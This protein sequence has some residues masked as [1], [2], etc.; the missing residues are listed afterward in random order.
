M[1]RIPTIKALAV[2]IKELNLDEYIAIKPLEKKEYY[3]LSSSQKRLYILKDLDEQGITYNIPFIV[4]LAGSLDNTRF[5][6][7]FHHLIQRHESLRT[8]FVLVNT[9]PAQRIHDKVEFEMEYYTSAEK[10]SADGIVKEFIRSF[11]LSRAP[12]LRVG[13]IKETGT[14]HIL[15][16]DMHHIIAD[17]VSAGV[18]AREFMLL[19]QGTDLPE[20]KIQYKD[21]SCWQNSRKGKEHLD[22]QQIYWQKQF[23]DQI[24]VLDIPTDFPRPAVQRF[25]G[26]TLHFEIDDNQSKILK[27]YALWQGATLYMVLLALY[28]IFLFKLTC[29]EDIVVGLP[30]AGRNHPDLENVVGMFVN[31]LVLRNFPVGTKNFNQ[32]LGEIKERALEAFSNQD[33]QYENLVEKIIVKRDVSRN[34]LFDT[35]FSLQNVP[36]PEINIQGLKLKPFHHENNISKFDLSLYCMENKDKVQC[37]FEYS[38]YLFE[39]ETMERFV[40]YFKRIISIV[41]ADPAIKLAGIE[42]I[43]PEEKQRLLYDFNNTGADYP[44]H[45][46]IH[47]LFEEQVLKTPNHAALVEAVE[48]EEKMSGIEPLRTPSLHITYVQL[49]QQSGHLAGLLIEK[50]A[51]PGTIVAI[52]TERSIELI[53]A[54]LG[55]LKVGCAYMPINP[56]NPLER[57]DLI[58][59][60]SG[61]KLLVTDNAY[62][63]ET[64]QRW[65]GERVLLEEISMFLKSSSYSLTCLP[66]CHLISSNLAYVIYTS[67]STGNPKGVPIAHANIAPLLHWGYRTLGLGSQDRT[68]QALAYYF[69]WSVWEIFITLTS[70]ARLYIVTDEVLLNPTACID[71][72]NKE[73]ITVLH[74]T[75]TQYRYLLN[76]QPRLEGL[77]YLL[78]G[79]EKLDSDIARRSLATVTG[80]CRVFNMYGPTE[81]TIISSVMEIQDHLLQEYQALNTMPIGRA[82]ANNALLVLDKYLNLCPTNV[83]GELYIAGD[84]LADGYLNDPE[85]THNVFISNI[86]KTN[87]TQASR[88]YKTGD[89][90]RWLPDGNIEYLERIDQQVKIRGNRIEIGEVQNKIIKCPGITEAVVLVKQ[91]KNK[92]N[93]LCAYVVLAKDTT[94]SGSGNG[95]SSEALVQP[96]W[97]RYLSGQLPDYMIPTEI[98]PIERIPLTP[99]GKLDINALP[100]PGIKNSFQDYNPPQNYIEE[101]L[102]EIWSHVLGVEK[103]KISIDANFFELGGHSLN[104]VSIIAQMLNKF[105]IRIPII[106]LFTRPTIRGMAAYIETAGTGMVSINDESLTLLKNNNRDGKNIFFI[107]DGSGDVEGYLAFCRE[108]QVSA[109]CWGIRAV[110]SENC[111]PQNVTIEEIAALYIEKIKKV[112]PHGPFA[113]A[114]WS[115]GGTIAFEIAA[116]LEK[117]GDNL[118]FLGLFD[119]PVPQ[120]NRPVVKPFSPESESA[121][122]CEY[123]AGDQIKEKLEQSKEVNETWAIIMDHLETNHFDENVVK[124]FIPDLLARV[125]PNFDRLNTR[126]LIHYLNIYRTL[127]NARDIYIPTQKIK[128]PLHY[129]Q[130]EQSPVSPGNTW[131]EYCL[132]QVVTYP[133]PGDHFSIFRE[134]NVRQTTKV[135]ENF[136]IN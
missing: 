132:N 51:I 124:T 133:I 44:R 135:F 93:Y 97:R 36:V 63:N 42:I 95:S 21:F 96:G 28:N 76:L 94:G 41:L 59:N 24:P 16:I 14:Q 8:S 101:T 55:I 130:A 131:N 68:L 117:Q 25:Q 129:F 128:T 84:G 134:P 125:I 89:I 81:T 82:V 111:S 3:P 120:K 83:P 20:T 64:L 65:K 60:D 75:P 11:D 70:G 103:T 2:Y 126:E 32:F 1:F 136:F 106:E 78:L 73:A 12:L 122:M 72:I 52:M 80:N 108:L 56:R 45:K 102:A 50:G 127:T 5:E 67:G 27:E 43:P 92:E 15:M 31:T 34:P 115:L 54:I 121:W 40:T 30:I 57:I 33:Y 116:Q 4:T 88:L 79:A 6:N 110:K 104:A 47:Q 38:T 58:L 112:Q 113:L 119:A 91:D 66:S 53:T 7:T 62:E 39:K 26:S 29:R 90:V 105:K 100:G 118:S 87:D 86:Y 123:L 69:D 46:T 48:G 10:R 109:N 71:A 35:M 22:Q 107:H 13:L 17:A 18:I 19:Y 77:R 37:I 23:Q 61:A 9:E 99:N 49:N 98:I 85:K 114:G 74:M